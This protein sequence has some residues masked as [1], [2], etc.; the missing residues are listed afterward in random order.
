[1]QHGFQQ[2]A[3]VSLGSGELGFQLVAYRHQFV[4][5]GDDAV[6][7]GERGEPEHKQFYIIARYTWN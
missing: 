5:F 3:A 6:L 2:A 4:H 1:M 7:L